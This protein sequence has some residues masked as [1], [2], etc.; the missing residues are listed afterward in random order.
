MRLKSEL[1]MW[2]RYACLSSQFNGAANRL[3]SSEISALLN[4]PIYDVIDVKDGTTRT[5]KSSQGGM[6]VQRCF[7]S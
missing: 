2:Q 1:L 5:D 7:D 6:E 3:M 4:N